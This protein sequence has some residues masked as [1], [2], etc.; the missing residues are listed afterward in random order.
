MPRLEMTTRT[1]TLQRNQQSKANQ[2]NQMPAEPDQKSQT[3]KLRR[4]YRSVPIQSGFVDAE[5]R[6]VDLTFS[7][8]S[9]C[10]RYFGQEILGHAPSEVD[11]SRITNGAPLLN[12]H[13]PGR[14]I[15]VIESAQIRDGKGFATVR[16]SRNAEA[17]DVFRD[18]QDGIKR[19]VSVGYDV[20]KMVLVSSS[21]QDNKK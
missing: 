12:Q 9:P 20:K 14:Q 13:D 16:F 11:M 2:L 18:V 1:L 10:D 6:T 19:N 21:G 7:S 4:Q 3:L 15:G 17:Q 8:E 5:K